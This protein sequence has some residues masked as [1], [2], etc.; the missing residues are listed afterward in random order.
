MCVFGG[1]MR[2]NSTENM[3]VENTKTPYYRMSQKNGNQ[4]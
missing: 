2:Q 3:K 4:N 1:D